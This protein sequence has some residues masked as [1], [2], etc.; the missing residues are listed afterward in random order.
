MG[1]NKVLV[2]QG[3]VKGKTIELEK[4]TGWPDGQRVVVYLASEEEIKNNRQAED[5]LQAIYRMRHMGRSIVNSCAS[6][7]T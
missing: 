5:T 1:D 6:S 7:S 4:E 2:F 3:V